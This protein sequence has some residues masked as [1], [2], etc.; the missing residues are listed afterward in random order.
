VLG[1]FQTI[2]Q[3]LI[4]RREP[5]QLGEVGTGEAP[6]DGIAVW[7]GAQP[8]QPSIDGIGDPA[9][10]TCGHR[11]IDELDH[12][13]M[14]K[15]QVL[16]KVAHG[17]SPAVR[18]GSHRE[19]ELVLRTREPSGL[20]LLLAPPLEAPETC[21]EP[22]QP[23]VLIV[24]DGSG[25][26]LIVTRPERAREPPALEHVC[27]RRP[28]RPTGWTTVVLA[29]EIRLVVLQDDPPSFGDPFRSCPGGNL[30]RDYIVLR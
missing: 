28:A 6:Q 30:T 8:D 2:P 26:L 9:Y 10:Q 12:A 16:R 3:R 18:V 1:R 13:V 14:A 25:H 24:G 23:F 27:M 15:H 4:D 5:R 21:P 19:E 7:G 11:T 17:G 22:Q 29:L 20:G